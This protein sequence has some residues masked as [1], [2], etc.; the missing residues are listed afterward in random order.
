MC[1]EFGQVIVGVDGRE[2]GRDAI[3]LARLLLASDGQLALA[4]IRQGG[5]FS[6]TVEDVAA[7]VES[8][9]PDYVRSLRLLESERR[10]ADVDARTITTVDTSAGHGLHEI[11]EREQADLL[12]IGSRHHGLLGRPLR[13]GEVRGSVNGCACAVAIAPSGYALRA[14]DVRTVG[15]GYDGGAEGEALL[16]VARGL[17]TRYGAIVRVLE[18]VELTG[19]PYD[20]W[21]GKALH[22]AREDSLAKAKKRVAD[23]D[24]VDGDAT[25]GVA[26]EQ[27][28]AL[29]KHV[30]VLLIGSSGHG[31]VH[32]LMLGSTSDFLAEHVRCPLLVLP[33]SHVPEPHTARSR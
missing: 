3:A 24:G 26:R 4:H 15:V 27:L 1:C 28:A 13:G 20:G 33:R 9:A 2:G 7:E 10:A 5:L 23:L 22:D 29:S 8:N 14:Y 32:R 16:A 18:V 17:A 6:P 21:G 19:W 25:I 11:V 31:S 30:D 12:A